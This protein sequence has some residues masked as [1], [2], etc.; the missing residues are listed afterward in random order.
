MSGASNLL[1]SALQRVARRIENPIRA[2]HGSPHSFDEFDMSRIGTGEGAQA[3]GH[4]L[5][6][7]ENEGVARGYRDA[8]TASNGSSVRPITNVFSSSGRE[9]GQ[10]DQA[11][12][13]VAWM[14]QE[15]GINPSTRD[16]SEWL[17]SEVAARRMGGQ[18]VPQERVLSLL[19]AGV[20]RDQ[21]HGS[22]YEVNLHARPEEFLDWD[23][24]VSA[25]SLPSS[26]RRSL[27]NMRAADR[28]SIEELGALS[29]KRGIPLS[30]R[31][32]QENAPDRRIGMNALHS[33][34]VSDVGG[35]Q[36]ATD[37]LAAEGI[38]GIRYL[39]QGSRTAGE[40]T[41]NYVV[42]DPR[43]IEITR[44][45]AMPLGILGGGGAGASPLRDAMREHARA[46]AA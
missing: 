9:L 32:L 45:Y 20:L 5:Y 33:Q 30:Q 43:I 27:D 3:Y 24:P 46:N 35:Q 21:R 41:R 44:R 42:F 15:H 28:R 1:R 12:A 16:G 38:P 34:L 6:F 18:D 26:M 39:D 25:D 11:A 10:A 17:A 4:G 29:A 19:R 31:I 7:A 2:Y 8:L 37:A 23:A 40:G 14:M 36:A 13:D 22:L